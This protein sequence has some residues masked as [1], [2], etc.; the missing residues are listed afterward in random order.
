VETGPRA[1]LSGVCIP[2]G[3]VNISPLPN[4]QTGCGSRGYRGAFPEAKSLGRFG[5]DGASAQPV[6]F[7]ITCTG[8]G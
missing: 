4:G 7:L 5:A 3:A 2:A 1:G 8:T 6:D